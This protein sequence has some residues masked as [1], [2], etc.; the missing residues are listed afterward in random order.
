MAIAK[1]NDIEIYYEIYGKGQP[2]VLI[3][4]Y[5]CDHAFWNGMLGKLAQH[6]QVLVFDNRAIGRS[7]DAGKPF[8]VET[9]AKDTINLI[10]HLKLNKPI[11]VGQSMGGAIA[12][13]VALQFLDKIS[14]L[15]ILNSVEKFNTV[16]MMALESLLN[17]RKTNIPF[18][19]LIETTLPWVF[20]KDY[21]TVQEYILAFKD[22]V[23]N[24]PAPQSIADQERQLQALKS[25]DS[26]LWI[27]K[28]NIPSLVLAANEDIISP[29]AEC[30]QLADNLNAKLIEIPGGHASPVE[31]SE[32]LNQ[33]ILSFLLGT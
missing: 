19:L 22:A 25:F 16:A 15:V 33:A 18:D 2:L 1:L 23:K 31:Q 32:R 24:N 10:E 6:F 11:I 12:Q 14:Q 7:K 27:K 30:Q 8:T 21:L 26:R 29:I 13:M 9:M 5:T 28:I 3:S 4:G 20:S 17:L